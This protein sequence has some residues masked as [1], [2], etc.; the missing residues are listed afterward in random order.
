MKTAEPLAEKIAREVAKAIRAR[1]VSS[2][3]HTALNNLAEGY[4][5][6]DMARMDEWMIRE[7]SRVKTVYVESYAG[8]QWD[9]MS[10][11]TSRKDR[12]VA[13][14]IFEEYAEK[15]PG[16]RIVVIRDGE[17]ASIKGR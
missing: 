12:K 14:G 13:Q 3:E 8:N 2:D 9:I 17:G 5:D 1:Y 6:G 15:H 10:E 7:L 4:M 16:A 11:G